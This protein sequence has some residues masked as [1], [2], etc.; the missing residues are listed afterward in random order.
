MLR[1]EPMRDKGLTHTEIEL[2]AHQHVSVYVYVTHDLLNLTSLHLPTGSHP[3]LLSLCHDLYEDCTY[4]SF[5]QF[6][7]FNFC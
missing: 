1:I 4:S 3:P 7:Q 2:C 5:V 6:S